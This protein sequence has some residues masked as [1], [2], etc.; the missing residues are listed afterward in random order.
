MSVPES[1]ELDLLTWTASVLHVH[2]VHL[3]IKAH[4]LILLIHYNWSEAFI[5]TTC[6]EVFMGTQSCEDEVGM[7]CF[8]DFLFPSSG[9]GARGSVVGWGTMLQAGRSRV[10]V[11]MRWIFFNLPNPSSHNMDLWSTQPLTEMS[12]RNLPGGVKRGWRVRLTTLLPSVSRLSRRCGSLD[13]SQPY[14]P[15]QPVTGI[16]LRNLTAHL[17]A[18]C[19]ENVGASTSHNPMGLHSLLQG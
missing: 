9:V 16:A 6:D 13:L 15:S 14:G 10:R 8:R 18:D 4:T 11:P 7:H 1:K 17:W 3:T 2:C 12:T 19:L 5:V